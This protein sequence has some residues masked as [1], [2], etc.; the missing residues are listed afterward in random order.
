MVVF[1]EPL[2][3][4]MTAKSG[5]W[6]SGMVSGVFVRL[7]RGVNHLQSLMVHLL[8]LGQGALNLPGHRAQDLSHVLVCRIDQQTVMGCFVF[9]EVTSRGTT[10]GTSIRPVASPCIKARSV[11]TYEARRRAVCRA[12]SLT[13]AT[14]KGLYSHRQFGRR[15]QRLDSFVG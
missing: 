13:K 14:R 1:P 6:T 11:K 2:A 5:R 4:A 15:I 10:S 7:P 3:L 8:R 9:H 12:F